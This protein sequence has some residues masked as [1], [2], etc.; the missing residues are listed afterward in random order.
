MDYLADFELD[1]DRLAPVTLVT[2]EGVERLDIAASKAEIAALTALIGEGLPNGGRVGIVVPTGARLILAWFAALAAR[3]EPVILQY[4]NEKQQRST[5][6]ESV[7]NILETAGLNALIVDTIDAAE[8]LTIGAEALIVLP[9]SRADDAPATVSISAAASFLQLSSGTTGHRKAVR[10]TL[11]DVDRHLTDYGQVMRYQADDVIVSWLPLYHDMGFVACFLA[12][13]LRQIPL[14]LIDPIHWVRTPVRLFEAIAQYRGTIAYMPNFGFEVMARLAPATGLESMRHWISC[15]EPTYAATIQKFATRHQV[16][17]ARISTCYAM[18]ENIFA[19]TQS[20]GFRTIGSGDDIRVSCGHPIPGVDLKVVEQELW[21][22]SPTALSGYVDGPD[23]RDA[24]G[25]YPTGDLGRLVDGE[26]VID[27]RKGDLINIAGRKFYLNDLDAL[28]NRLDESIRGRAATLALPHPAL[29]TQRPLVL[30]EHPEFYRQDPAPLETRMRAESGIESLEVA[31]VPPRFVT[32]TTSGKV[33]RKHT[34]QDWIEAEAWRA[35]TS[36][37]RPR[38]LREEFNASFARA[39]HA[40]PVGDALDSL[41]LTLLQIVLAD[42]GIPYDPARSLTDILAQDA[43]LAPD[44]DTTAEAVHLL[45]IGEREL[46]RK[47]DDAWLA[48][49]SRQIGK[50]VIFEHFVGPPLAVVLSDVIFNDYFATRLTAEQR[51]QAEGFFDRIARVKQA[52]LIITDDV[53][54]VN[55]TLGQSFWALSHDLKRDPRADLVAIRQYRYTSGHH[56]LP[57]TVLSGRSDLPRRS[58]A[59]RDLSDYLDIPV[60]GVAMLNYRTEWTNDW[61][62]QALSVGHPNPP[63]PW[64]VPMDEIAALIVRELGDRAER[65]RTAP[66]VSASGIARE[67]L[68]H[69]CTN[70]IVQAK[71]DDLIAKYDRFLLSGPQASVPYVRKMLDKLGKRWLACDGVDFTKVGISEDDFDVVF[72]LGSWGKPPTAKPVYQVLGG[73]WTDAALEALPGGEHYFVLP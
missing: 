60:F 11:A 57:L 15:S 2:D 48:E 71:L 20:D 54:E 43:P 6:C 31:Y 72:Q 67:A 3:V 21:V 52:A 44:G 36:V 61:A 49:I 22:R 62:V 42:R 32:K 53:A 8:G 41:G 16:A 10:F 23:I 27:G 56:A 30:V 45:W 25:Y 55:L 7:G 5:W 66:H 14:V 50:P 12:A 46:G 17:L 63:V 33:N 37:S 70:I 4:Y 35:R 19:V 59:F 9:Q 65:V 28:A 18:A 1:L 26:L 68:P 38:T 24:E 47:I 40:A 73:G 58:Q 69:L 29:G 13:M 39:D 51:L 64:P 34:A